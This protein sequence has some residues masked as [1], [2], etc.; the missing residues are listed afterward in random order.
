MALLALVYSQYIDLFVRAFAMTVSAEK[1][2]KE[3]QQKQYH[4]KQKTQALNR[5]EKW[6][7][8]KNKSQ[9]TWKSGNAAGKL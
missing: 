1:V 9:R 5:R 8:M 6:T 7:L 3:C 2:Q 4:N